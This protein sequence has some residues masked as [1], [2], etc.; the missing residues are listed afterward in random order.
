VAL[1]GQVTRMR[2]LLP[3]IYDA[4][5]QK[6]AILS[7]NFETEYSTY[8]E[9]PAIECTKT[10]HPTEFMALKTWFPIS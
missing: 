5:N 1:V 7:A 8:D 6:P 10:R 3:V 4:I 2:G 9:Q